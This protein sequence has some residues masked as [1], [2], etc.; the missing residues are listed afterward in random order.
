[1][2]AKDP[3]LRPRIVVID[4]CQRVFADNDKVDKTN[5]KGPT[6]GEIATDIA[7]Q[8][9]NAA[10]KYGIVLILLTPEPTGNSLPRKLLSVFT[11]KACG[12]IGDQTSNDAVLGTGSYKAG[13]SAVGLEPKTDDALN[14]CGTLMTKGFT[15][16]PGLLRSYYVSVADATQVTQ[17][18]MRLREGIQPAA[19]EPA[20]A[21]DFLDDLDEVMGAEVKVRTDE[22]RHRLIELHRGTYGTWTPQD[23]IAAL[24]KVG[25]QARK[26][27]GIMVVRA[28]DVADAIDARDEAA[29]IDARDE[30]AE[31]DARDEAAEIDEDAAG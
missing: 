16:K 2:A 25:L 11:H 1:M 8:L 22:V 15:P 6:R 27:N 14:D 17:R 30:A 5:K 9:V 18:A 24:A 31:I 13:I 23:L 12:S 26:S 4:E 10:R 29:E 3:K 21:R 20:T 7:V 19:I 28:V